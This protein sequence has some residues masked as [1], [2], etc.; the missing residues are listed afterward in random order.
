VYLECKSCWLY[1]RGFK[2]PGYMNPHVMCGL[3]ELGKVV[4]HCPCLQCLTKTMCRVHCKERLT[5][6]DK[7]WFF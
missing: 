4:K 2:P 1:T 5:F 7:R 3:Y 6:W